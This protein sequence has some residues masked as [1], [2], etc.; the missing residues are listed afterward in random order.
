MPTTK[1]VIQFFV[2]GEYMVTVLGLEY[3]IVDW[4]E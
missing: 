3:R 4:L 1:A 2:S